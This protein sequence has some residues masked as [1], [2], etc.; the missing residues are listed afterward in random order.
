MNK[1]FITGAAGFI[2]SRFWYMFQDKY[3]MSGMDKYSYCSQN[4]NRMYEIWHGDCSD[5][6]IVKTALE[7]EKPDILVIAQASSHNDRSMEDPGLFFRDNALATQVLLEEARRQGI[8]RVFIISTDEVIKH[9]PPQ[10]GN[11]FMFD[12][13]LGFDQV[14]HRSR[15]FYRA[16]EIADIEWTFFNP[17][18]P[19]SASKASMEFIVNAYRK[20]FQMDN[21]TIIRPTNVFGP[22]QFP[23][24][25]ISQSIVK[26]LKG[27]PIPIY[28]EGEEWRDFTYVDDT[29]RALDLIFSQESPEPLYHISANDERQNINTVRE[30]LRQTGQSEDLIEFVQHNRG[31]S[32][33]FSYS[34]SSARIRDLGWAPKVSFEEGISR[35]IQYYKNLTK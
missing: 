33:D 1:I 18:S 16:R 10:K 27:E 19:Y 8:K 11:Y 22:R 35:T 12:G 30:I 31:K 5:P 7:Q 6:G 3:R 32:H 4:D 25:L 20:A 9:I 13:P 17:T 15:T 21:I 2:M 14:T 34:L 28:S 29:C 23:E 24:K 26:A